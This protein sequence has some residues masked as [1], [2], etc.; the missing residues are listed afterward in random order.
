MTRTMMALAA[1]P[2]V[3][4]AGGGAAVAQAASGPAAPAVVQQVRAQHSGGCG[5]QARTMTVTAQ[6]DRARA[7]DGT[8]RR[9]RTCDATQRRDRV[10]AG[11]QSANP[12]GTG[13]MTRA[14]HGED[15]G[16]GGDR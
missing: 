1:V 5:D 11:G 9:D 12:A 10:H 13:M 16:W 2:A 14:H 6:Q 4:L 8:Q 3:L 15:H 7:C